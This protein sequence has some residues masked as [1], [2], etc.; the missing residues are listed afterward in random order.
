MYGKN[1]LPTGL[2]NIAQ[3][4]FI[5]PRKCSSGNGHHNSWI[6]HPFSRSYLLVLRRYVLKCRPC[7]WC[8]KDTKQQLGAVLGGTKCH[9]LS[10]NF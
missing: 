1:K 6:L 10:A 8:F 4:R 3:P 2:L 5:Q 7:T 9:N